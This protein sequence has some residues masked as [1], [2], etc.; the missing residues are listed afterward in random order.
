[1]PI[2]SAETKSTSDFDLVASS[3]PLLGTLGLRLMVHRHFPPFFVLFFIKSGFCSNMIRSD[4]FTRVRV[5]EKNLGEG[6]M[7][8]N[9]CANA[10]GCVPRN[11]CKLSRS[12][13]PVTL[14][15]PVGSGRFAE[16]A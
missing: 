12:F 10:R 2:F 9:A 5:K 14:I 13:L 3:L 8:G 7:N 1:M 16:R 11:G 6:D 15:L 4:G